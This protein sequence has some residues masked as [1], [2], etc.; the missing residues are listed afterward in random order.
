MKSKDV[1]LTFTAVLDLSFFQ[2]LAS[3]SALP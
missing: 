1:L 2:A 3:L